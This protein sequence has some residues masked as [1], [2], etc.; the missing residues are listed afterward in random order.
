MPTR[1][2]MFATKAKR[3]SGRQCGL[4]WFARRGRRLQKRRVDEWQIAFFIA[5]IHDGRQL[6]ADEFVGRKV[7]R[8]A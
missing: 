8:I 6:R 3:G 1:T 7:D 5:P 4:P 2:A